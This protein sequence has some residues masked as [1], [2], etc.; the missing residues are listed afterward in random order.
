[1]S[2]GLHLAGPG[3]LRKIAVCE[4]R[5]HDPAITDCVREYPVPIDPKK[6]REFAVEVVTRLREAG[7]TAYWAGGCVRDE[8]LGRP[9]VDYDVATDASPDEVRDIFGR[10]RT[11]AV[12]AAFGVITVLGP[13]GAGQVEVATFRSDLSYSDGRRPDAVR[14]A[15]PQEDALRR[16]FTINGL[17][18]DPL[19]HEVIDYVHG[20]EDLRA[21]IIRAIGDPRV[22]FAEDYLR[23][24]RAVRFVA[25]LRFKLDEGTLAAIR[26][27]SERIQAVSR[28]RIAAELEKL[29]TAEGRAEAVQ[30]LHESGLL[31]H[32]LPAMA[33]LPAANEPLW[34]RNLAVLG[35]LRRPNVSSALAALVGGAIAPDDARRLAKGLRLSSAQGEELAW[36]LEHRQALDEAS[37]RPWSQIQPILTSPWI[38]DLLDLA[39]ARAEVEGRPKTDLDWCREKRLLP[40]EALNPPPLIR[41]DDLI[42]YD[43]PAGPVYRQILQDAWRNQLDGRLQTREEALAWLEERVAAKRRDVPTTSTEDGPGKER[44][45]RQLGAASP[46]IEVEDRRD[47]SPAAPGSNQDAMSGPYRGGGDTAS[48]P[49]SLG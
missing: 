40:P 49:P 16:D 45:R 34:R 12:G 26:E 10:R 33:S 23:M 8:L 24:L 30:L 37:N 20:L 47:E 3:C 46:A 28:E 18:Y 1:M 7:Y 9:P 13:R 36:L 15:T 11:H 5:R 43:L 42:R 2:D 48:S 29:L 38:D 25:Q 39:E 31:P 17:F 35:R 44:R 32:I 21:R 22:R 41:G 19:S 14:F 6:Q 27:M 4:R